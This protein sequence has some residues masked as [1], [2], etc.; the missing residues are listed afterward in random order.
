V[1]GLRICIVKAARSGALSF[2]RI[3]SKLKK[4]EAEASPDVM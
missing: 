2:M 4:G 1:L 3:C